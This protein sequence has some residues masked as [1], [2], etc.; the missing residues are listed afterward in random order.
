[1][2]AEESVRG[3]AMRRFLVGYFTHNIIL[4]FGVI[5]K[6][7]ENLVRASESQSDADH[8]ERPKAAPGRYYPYRLTEVSPTTS[9]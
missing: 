7:F 4:S 8:G 5:T 9:L 6:P 1:M 3:T 2:Q